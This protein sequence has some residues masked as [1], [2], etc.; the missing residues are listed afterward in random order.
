VLN[1]TQREAIW[2][3]LSNAFLDDDIDYNRLAGA[4]PAQL[5]Q[6][7]FNEV[8][9]YCGPQMLSVIPPTFWQWGGETRPKPSK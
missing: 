1:D 2:V 9:L 4:S 8:A 5:E 3:A 6:I 7:F